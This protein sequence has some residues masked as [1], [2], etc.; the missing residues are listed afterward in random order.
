MV[1]HTIH[2]GDACSVHRP[3][4]WLLFSTNSLLLCHLGGRGT[5]VKILV[6][7]VKDKNNILMM[8]TQMTMGGK[9]YYPA[10]PALTV[11]ST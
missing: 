4:Q 10:I 6:Q 2:T 8:K 3:L 11:P 7:L 9:D 1:T 5:T